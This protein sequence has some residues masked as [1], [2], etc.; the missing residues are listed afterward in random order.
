MKPS[1]KKKIVQLKIAHPLSEVIAHP[2]CETTVLRHADF[3]GSTAALLKYCQQSS[4]R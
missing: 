2:E 1:R 4:E 3:I